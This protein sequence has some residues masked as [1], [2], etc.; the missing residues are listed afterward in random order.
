[1]QDV[2]QA[3]NSDKGL[4]D[5]A[6]QLIDTRF[7]FVGLQE[8]FHESVW[9]LQKFLNMTQGLKDEN[10]GKQHPSKK[11]SMSQIS[12]QDIQTTL[13]RNQF[14]LALYNHVLQNVQGTVDEFNVSNMS[15]AKVLAEDLILESN[16][17]A[18]YN[19]ALKRLNGHKTI[20]DVSMDELLAGDLEYK[21]L[22][23]LEDKTS[24][25]FEL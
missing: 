24:R 1:M 6:L 11:P 2:E 18:L 14:D 17:L 25:P 12:S 5:E 20:W 21:L 7:A 23:G 22:M 13:E 8:H 9:G 10:I 19:H 15:M 16:D 3:I 4:M